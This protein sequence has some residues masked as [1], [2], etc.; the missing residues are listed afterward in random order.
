MHPVGGKPL[1]TSRM[2]DIINLQGY[3]SPTMDMSKSYSGILKIADGEID[4]ELLGCKDFPND[5]FITH[6]LTSNGKKITLYSCYPFSRSMSMPGI[7]TA[8]LSATHYFEGDHLEESGFNFDIAEIKI[9]FLDLWLSVGGFTFFEKKENPYS[10]SLTYEL[11]ET[12]TLFKN[13]QLEISIV[14]NYFSPNF[15]PNLDCTIRQESVIQIKHSQT[16]NLEELWTYINIISS[17]FTLSYFSEVNIED[18]ILIK[19]ETSL[20]VKYLRQ[21]TSVLDTK[22]HRRHFLF[23]YN[24]VHL[25]LR[26][27]FEKW[28]ALHKNLEPVLAIFLEIFKKQAKLNEN[29]FLNIMHGIESFHRRLRSNSNRPQEEYLKL[30]KD[31]LDSAPIEHKTWLKEKLA[32]A[33][34]PSLKERLESLFSEIE[35]SIL[36]HLFP[37]HEK[38]IVQAKNT[39]NYFTHYS[40]SLAKKALQGKELYYLSERFK[41]LLLILLLKETGFEDMQ[42]SK[43]IIDS[44]HFLF[45]HIIVKEN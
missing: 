40:L 4:L 29:H 21:N 3:W 27:I 10:L 31:I 42:I 16:F 33:N 11:P 39:R 7:P 19:G 5:R 30:I 41:L 34:E 24:Q 25:N 22:K 32:F 6:G 43:I 17:F 36:T 26:E 35:P 38:L 14:F 1:N 12:I 13:E 28:Y 44:S 23:D 20:K 45:N 8:T 9:T 15:K 18:I 2:T 37:M